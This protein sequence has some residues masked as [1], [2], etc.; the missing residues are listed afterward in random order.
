[1]KTI[2]SV[3][4]SI[5]HET[6]TGLVAAAG[7]EPKNVRLLEFRGDGIYAEVYERDA[8][9]HIVVDQSASEAAVNRV[10]IPVRG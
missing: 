6:Y 9:G 7:F 5:T 3:P 4:E 2:T 1:M 10:W 8:A